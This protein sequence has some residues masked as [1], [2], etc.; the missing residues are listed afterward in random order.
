MR[1]KELL[2]KW[3]GLFGCSQLDRGWFNLVCVSRYQIR[4]LVVFEMFFAF[5]N[6]RLH[7]TAS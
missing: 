7:Q 1:S 3:E 4:P 2:A 6:S 5:I